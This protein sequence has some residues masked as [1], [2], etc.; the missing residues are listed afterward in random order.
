MPTLTRL[1]SLL[2]M[3][4]ATACLGDQSSWVTDHEVV[5]FERVA[6]DRWGAGDPGGY[7]DLYT[8]EVTYFDPG[9]EARVNGY[10]GMEEHLDPIRGLVSIDRY[11]IVEPKVLLEGKAAILTFNLVSYDQGDDGTE[12]VASRWNITEVYR[13]VEDAWRIEH[14]HFSLTQPQ[15]VPP[16]A[17]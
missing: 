7:L 16:S 13:Q 5:A 12:Q 17:P 2:L 9:T 15:L 1:V 6:L 3:F 14:S 8:P 4:S 11:E 10:A